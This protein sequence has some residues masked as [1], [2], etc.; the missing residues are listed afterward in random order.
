MTRLPHVLLQLIGAAL[1]QATGRRRIR[2]TAEQVDATP[3]Q[4]TG[5]R[6]I[7]FRR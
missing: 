1:T 7:R 3:T 5:R 2:T 4:P 6:R